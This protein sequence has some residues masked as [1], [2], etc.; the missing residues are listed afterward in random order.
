V[1]SNDKGA[2][3]NLVPLQPQ[4]A[5]PV[6][7]GF[8]TDDRV[9]VW[10]QSGMEAGIEPYD[11]KTGKNLRPILL[12]DHGRS[13]GNGAASPDGRGFAIVAKD[14]EKPRVVLYQLAGSAGARQF[15]L[16]SLDVQWADPVAMAFS[17][18]GKHLAVLFEKDGNAVLYD[19]HV[20]EGRTVGPVLLPAGT[21]PVAPP[22]AL[23][24]DGNNAAA[25]CPHPA[26]GRQLSWLADDTSL[27][28]RGDTVIDAD[29][30]QIKGHLGAKGTVNQ[31]VSGNTC[32]LEYR[33]ET[34]DMRLARV[35]LQGIGAPA[36]PQP[37]AH[38]PATRPAAA[39]PA[40]A[41]ASGASA[42]PPRG[43][44][45]SPAAPHVVPTAGPASRAH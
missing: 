24:A 10:W 28:V 15:I 3:A 45:A 1:W 9:L 11:L 22:S 18:D 12:P 37:G 5:K 33:G 29:T 40:P 38:P 13:P 41:G 7:L 39:A 14:K 31:F 32:L 35:K 16:P 43:P 26:S 2:S 30:G 8:L 17:P 20:A 6:L 27:L 34:G 42:A 23:P 21:L 44:A 25:N 36:Q 4:N 19:C